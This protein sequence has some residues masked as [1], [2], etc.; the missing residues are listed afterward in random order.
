MRSMTRLLLAASLTAAT[1]GGLFLLGGGGRSPADPPPSPTAIPTDLPDTPAPSTAV[2]LEIEG[3]W[4]GFLDE[5][6]GVSAGHWYLSLGDRALARVPG[7]RGLDFG[8][9]AVQ[10]GGVVLGPSQDCDGEGRYVARQPA[11]HGELT[12]TLVSDAC[13]VR[14]AILTGPRAGAPAVGAPNVPWYRTPTWLLATGYR[15]HL[16]LADP[17]FSFVLPESLP[18]AGGY[19]AEAGRDAVGWVF[20]LDTDERDVAGYIDPRGYP[21]RCRPVG[22]LVR[23][24]SLDEF[25]EW[26]RLATGLTVSDPEPLTVAGRAAVHVVVTAGSDCPGTVGG[27]DMTSALAIMPGES[28]HLWA[29]DLGNDQLLVIAAVASGPTDPAVHAVELVGSIAFR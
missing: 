17:A 28:E 19:I 9:L 22:D 1:A 6:E 18:G 25:V 14:S 15:Y 2:A 26:N 4:G 16:D 3:E 27:P 11:D 10:G 23:I 8:V 24:R 7:S 13:A 5:A 20:A 29:I 21:D 12:F